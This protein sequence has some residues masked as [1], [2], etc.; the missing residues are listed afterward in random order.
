MLVGKLAF[1]VFSF[2]LW[3]LGIQYS[4]QFADIPACVGAEFSWLR[5]LIS[6]KSRPNS[7]GLATEQHRDD[8]DVYMCR[9][10]QVVK[11]HQVLNAHR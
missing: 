10:R 7:W 6:A 4:S 11:V 1:L 8:V 9:I 2:L 3:F 5:Q